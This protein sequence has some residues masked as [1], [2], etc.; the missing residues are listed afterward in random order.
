MRVSKGLKMA[1]DVQ[2]FT[3]AAAMALK[4]SFSK[5][6]KL[7][8]TRDDAQAV[9]AVVRAWEIAQERVRIQRGK[10]LPGVLKPEAKRRRPKCQVTVLDPLPDQDH[11]QAGDQADDQADDQSANHLA[12]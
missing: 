1:Y 10:P 4:E 3:F 2:D 7:K 5:D 8:L 11:D 6:G 9:N 12:M